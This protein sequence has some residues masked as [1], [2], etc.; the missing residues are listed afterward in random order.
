MRA[1]SLRAVNR[2]TPLDQEADKTLLKLTPEVLLGPTTLV[3]LHNFHFH[4]SS[5][6]NIIVFI[7]RLRF[8]ISQTPQ[9]LSFLC[10]IITPHVSQV[11]MPIQSTRKSIIVYDQDNMYTCIVCRYRCALRLRCACSTHYVVDQP[12]ALKGAWCLVLYL[13]LS[14][15][16]D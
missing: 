1:Q 5:H 11:I 3:K 15:L 7:V 10:F 16:T 12:S 13:R 9:L 2:S 14:K 6:N 4:C 8:I